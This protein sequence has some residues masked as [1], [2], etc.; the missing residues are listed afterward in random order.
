MLDRHITRNDISVHVIDIEAMQ[1]TYKFP[2][3]QA[4]AK[5]MKLAEGIYISTQLSFG[6]LAQFLLGSATYDFGIP[7]SL[8]NSRS[9]W[10]DCVYYYAEGD[11]FGKM[12]NVKATFKE[13][14]REEIKK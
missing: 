9:D 3:D 5:F 7:A 13:F 2:I 10:R 14:I 6:D 12:Y 8:W 4:D 11:H 1:Y